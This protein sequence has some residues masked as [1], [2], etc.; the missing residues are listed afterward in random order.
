MA[1]SAN[2][3]SELQVF[4]GIDSDATLATGTPASVLCNR[5]YDLADYYFNITT[6]VQGGNAQLLIESA[7]TV[8]GAGVSQGAVVGTALA[9]LRPATITPG[10]GNNWLAAGATV[11]R[12]SFLRATAS[13]GDGALR[14]I[15]F[16]SIMPGNRYAAGNG[17][18]YPNNGAALG[19]QA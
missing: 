2:V 15:G 7:A 19:Y 17:T 14:A 16:I 1:N 18:Y 12:G 9:S 8:A 10:V 13:A 5:E 4:V 11:A 6:S 3:R